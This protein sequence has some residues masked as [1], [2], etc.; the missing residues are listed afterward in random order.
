MRKFFISVLLIGLFVFVAPGSWTVYAGIT[1]SG[2]VAI[3]GGSGSCAKYVSKTGQTTLY[4]TGDDG[5]LEK[6]DPVSPRFT[7]NGDGTITD[8]ATDLVWAKDG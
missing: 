3:S 1:I 5:D 7:D 4:A 6:G 2:D 8:N